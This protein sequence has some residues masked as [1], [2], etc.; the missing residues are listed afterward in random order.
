VDFCSLQSI[1][2]KIRKKNMFTLYSKGKKKEIIRPLIMAV[3]NCTND[4]FYEASRATNL[5]SIQA[6]I[7][8]FVYNGADIIDVGGRSSRPGSVEI[9]VEEE[10]SRITDAIL[11]LTSSYPEQWVSIDST[12]AEVARFAVENGVHIVNDIS[13][14]NMDPE[15]MGTVSQLQVPF[16]CMHMQGTP[17]TMQKNPDYTNVVDDIYTFFEEKVIECKNSGINQI[18]ID[19]GFGFG[20]TL[21]HNYQLVKSLSKFK[22]LN[23]PVLV[24]FSRKSMIYKLLNIKPEEALNGTTVLNTY[25]LINGASILRVHDVQEAKEAMLILDAIQNA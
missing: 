16:I 22:S 15:M 5:T 17:D 8:D 20:K 24:G 19:P 7:D 25:A 4:S 2:T 14:G 11:Y 10:I 23:V 21:E 1:A 13:G 6:K 3:L 12:S 18:I 9:S